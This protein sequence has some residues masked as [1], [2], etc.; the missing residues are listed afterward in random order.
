MESENRKA[1]AGTGSPEVGRSVSASGLQTNLHDLGAG[2]TVILVHGSGPGVSAYANWRLTMP[3]LARHF[4]VIAPDM[5]G[6]GFTERSPGWTYGMDSWLGHLLGVMDALDV[7]KAHFVGNS[8]GGALALAL[9]AR[10]PQRVNRLVL[11]GSAGVPFSLT[12]G[13]DS[14]WGYTPSIDNM[15]ALLDTFAFNRQLVTDELAKLRYQ[16]S[17]QP[18]FQ[19][20][21]AA[22]FPAPR[23]RW[24]DALQTPEAA[25]RA[26]PHEVMIVHGRDDKVIP[27]ETSI[28]LAHWIRQSQLHVYGQCGHWTQIERAAN[29]NRLVTSFLLE[30]HQ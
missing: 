6:F 23:Q 27:L 19:E 9:A 17:I 22:M 25:V 1:Q 18:G 2:D 10:Y 5:A 28:L 8:F 21:F 15:R 3:V 4:R 13:L 20:S 12:P 14:V 30:G 26:L 29:F 11:M 7:D 16:A 24:V